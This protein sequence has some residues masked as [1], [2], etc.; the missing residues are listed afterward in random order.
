VTTPPY[1][2]V[3]A[4]DEL[5]SR[6]QSVLPGFVVRVANRSQLESAALRASVVFV[7][8]DRVDQLIGGPID[9]PIVAIVDCEPSDTFANTI[10]TL[11]SCPSVCHILTA[12]L[13]FSP[14]AH[15]HLAALLERFVAGPDHLLIGGRGVARV[16]LLA[17]SEKRSAR[18]ARMDEFFSKHNVSE[19]TVST[20]LD[21][22]E[23]LVMNALYDAPSESGYFSR[24][25]QRLE[26]VE[27]PVE[28]ACEIC[29]GV[30]DEMVF[31]RVRDHFGSLSRARLI[32]VLARCNSQSVALDESRGGAGLGLWR[33][34]SAAS[35]ISITVTQERLTDVVV[36]IA[37]TKQGRGYAKQLQALHLFFG[38]QSEDYE[39][40]SIT[41]DDDDY[42]L[43]NHGV[44]DE[45]V[46]LVCV[47]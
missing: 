12:S 47:A 28:L 14:R 41:S 23:E 1:S 24:P 3:F 20:I 38:P 22:S 10:G 27:L 30:E 4:G 43:S 9:I 11:A 25:R 44:L 8:A 6:L 13:L 42:A 33:V 32:E 36:G 16:A 39:M 46:T 37:T 17:S 19:R 5:S 35:M 18:L 29:Y 45:S 2:V 31:V 26:N 34:F 21:V 15:T 40:L 7:G